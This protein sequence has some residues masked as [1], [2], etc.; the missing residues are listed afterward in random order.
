MK[1]D[2]WIKTI[3]SFYSLTQN[4]AIT[5]PRFKALRILKSYPKT[6]AFQSELQV[7]CKNQTGVKCM[8]PV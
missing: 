4:K 5:I 8:V 7:N 2:P 6:K 1:F 3:L